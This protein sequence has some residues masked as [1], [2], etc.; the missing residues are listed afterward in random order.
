[1]KEKVTLNRRESTCNEGSEAQDIRDQ[2]AKSYLHGM[3]GD[4]MLE[5]RNVRD[6]PCLIPH[7]NDLL[8]LNEQKSQG[9]CSTLSQYNCMY[10]R[11]TMATKHAQ[12]SVKKCKMS[13]VSVKYEPYENMVESLN[14][15]TRLMSYLMDHAVTSTTE[16]YLY[17]FA[18]I[19][20][21]VGG[22][23]GLFLGFSC[24]S[25]GKSLMDR[26]L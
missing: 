24:Y 17:D 26:F 5:C 9:Q 11:L 12:Q 4:M 6:I 8:T 7:A 22:N 16:Y 25:T 15:T 1:M 20:S 23:M 18:A 2:T 19:V 21:A 10:A 14:V 13:S 3:E